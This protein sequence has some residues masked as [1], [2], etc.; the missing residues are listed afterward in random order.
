MNR[1]WPPCMLSICINRENANVDFLFRY[2]N[3][4][5]DMGV[6]FVQFLEPK[7]IGNYKRKRVEL[8]ER[9]IAILEKFYLQMNLNRRFQTYPTIIYHGYQNR[10][11]GCFSSGKY[12]LYIDANGDVMTC[13]FCRRKEGNVMDEDLGVIADRMIE[14]G[15][16]VY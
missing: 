6:A 9:E 4:A 14:K 10:R 12:S 1:R 16:G 8:G 15:C 5:R 7:S 13:T 3:L 11:A 2:M